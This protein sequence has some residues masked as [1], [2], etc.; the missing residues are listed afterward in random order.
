MVCVS[1]LSHALSFAPSPISS[2]V[3]VGVLNSVRA[4]SVFAVSS[5]LFCEHQVSQC[6]TARK[7]ASTAIVIIGALGYSAATSAAA[8]SSTARQRALPVDRRQPSRRNSSSS[9]GIL[10]RSLSAPFLSDV[11]A[12]S[13][14][15]FQFKRRKEADG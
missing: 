12:S 11:A 6:Y 3:P 13:G 9:G 2:A 7:G 1:C 10:E 8:A 4:V 14:S 15:W 5:M